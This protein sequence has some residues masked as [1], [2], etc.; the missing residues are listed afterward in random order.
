V[1]LSKLQS[2]IFRLLA[3][4]RDPESYIAGSTYL[5]RQGARYS[6][7][8]DIF[9]DR[10]ER[11]A[12]AAGAD[13]AVLRDAGK[14]VSWQRREPLFYQALV[15]DA[16]A[17]TKLEWVVDSDFRFYPAQRDPEFG[18][19]LHPAD[20]ATNK[21]MA[22]AGRREPRDIVDLIDIHDG[23]LPLGAVAWAAVGRSLGFTPEGLINEV[24]RLARYT[25]ADFERIASDPPV[26]ADATMRRLRQALE[27]A[28][29]FVRRMPTDKIGVLFLR[30][31][32]AVQ[33]DP[34]HLD[35]YTMHAGAHRGHWPSSP[36]IGSAMLERY[37][38]PSR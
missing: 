33:P 27:E 23:I 11:V 6:G 5:T 28:D 38:K 12:Q 14:D 10:E 35:D 13:A 18:Y 32:Q 19:V 24:R 8:I 26:D 1:P 22:A 34:D 36:E 15:T 4:H 25:A 9:H 30:D 37:G 17:S 16:G 29:A 3:G 20:L 7:D 31:G 2:E 21:I